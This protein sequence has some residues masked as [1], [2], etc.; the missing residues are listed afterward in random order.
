MGTI[1]FHPKGRNYAKGRLKK[2]KPRYRKYKKLF[3]F[4]F[5]LNLGLTVYLGYLNGWH[6]TPTAQKIT[7]YINEVIQYVW[8]HYII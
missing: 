8:T 6:E 1:R 4:S 5:L 7:T 3:W 2:I